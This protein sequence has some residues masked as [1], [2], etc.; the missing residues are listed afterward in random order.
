MAKITQKTIE[1]FFDQ[2]G[3]KSP[4]KKAKLLPILTDVIYEYNMDVVSYEKEKDEYRRKQILTEIKENEERIK[5]IVE[6]KK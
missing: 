5:E 1:Q 3:V 4:D 6:E 2:F